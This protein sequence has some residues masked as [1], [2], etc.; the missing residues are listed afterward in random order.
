MMQARP[1]GSPQGDERQAQ[2]STR[3]D[4]RTARNDSDAMHAPTSAH[5]T[6]AAAG[7][8]IP[9]PVAIATYA[10]THAGHFGITASA[11]AENSHPT[12][13]NHEVV[14]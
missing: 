14:E 4:R 9:N 11:V 5:R 6:P 8:E 1:F 10:A 12:T 2:A 3:Q 7:N 13:S